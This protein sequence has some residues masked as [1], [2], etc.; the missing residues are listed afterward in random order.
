MSRRRWHA[1]QGILVIVL[2]VAVLGTLL[3]GLLLGASPS[4]SSTGSA[5]ASAM[6]RADEDPAP[7][8]PGTV[9]ALPTDVEQMP[10]V[11]IGTSREGFQ[12]RTLLLMVKGSDGLV[13]NAVLL[14]TSDERHPASALMIP[15]SLLVPT[16][17][18]T[19]LSE[20][21]SSADTLLARNALSM[22]LGVR[23]DASLILDRLAFAAI[24]DA[25][26]GVPAQVDRPITVVDAGEVVTDVAAG[27]RVLDGVTA[28]DYAT[29]MPSGGQESDRIAR[30]S[31]VLRAALRDLPTQPE[32]LRQLV[33]S[34]GS[35][36]KSTQTNEQIVALLRDLGR[37]SVAGDIQ[38]QTLPVIVVRG[39]GPV[40]VDLAGA[41]RIIRRT[42]PDAVLQPGESPGVRVMLAS[43]GATPGEMA[44]AV[45]RLEAE[46]FTVIEAGLAPIHLSSTAIMV[47]DPSPVARAMGLDVSAALGMPASAVRIDG[48]TR[49]IPDVV[50]WLGRDAPTLASGTAPRV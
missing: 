50:V 37:D 42:L 9:P 38:Y 30:F 5:D 21:A 6:T 48:G 31:A 34:L 8:S 11:V 29:A 13:A 36:A 24:V 17:S 33:L 49:P 45:A 14:A 1:P 32:D 28:T 20:T 18:W 3:V 7:G 25:I 27:S 19:S 22:L 23:I 39:S 41:S 12:Q 40:Q 46:G 26:G 35:L 2:G 16:P 10:A 43:A 47:Q 4:T 15:P 44:A